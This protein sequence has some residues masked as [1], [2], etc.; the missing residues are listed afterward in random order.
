MALFLVLQCLAYL[1][2]VLYPLSKALAANWPTLSQ[3][4][5]ALAVWTYFVLGNLGT[6]LG[7]IDFIQGKKF[8]KWTPVKSND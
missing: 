6:L 2:I 8:G 4:Q 7:L 5:R 3:A 1:S